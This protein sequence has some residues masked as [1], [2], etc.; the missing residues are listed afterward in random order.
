MTQQD[1]AGSGEN[2]LHACTALEDGSVILAGSTEGDWA[3]THSGGTDFALVKLNALGLEEWR[4]QVFT[5]AEKT[6]GRYH[7]IPDKA[8]LR[9][10]RPYKIHVACANIDDG[11]FDFA[12]GI[13]GQPT[14]GYVAGV[15]AAGP[16]VDVVAQS[17]R[18]RTYAMFNII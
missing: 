7:V 14:L 2:L 17:A 8:R 5:I 6:D 13:G 18:R 4:W 9:L 16:A 15:Y 11:R 12:G 1:G 10:A 3:G